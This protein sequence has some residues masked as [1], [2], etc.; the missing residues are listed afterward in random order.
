[1]HFQFHL[2]T[3]IYIGFVSFSQVVLLA[4]CCYSYNTLNNTLYS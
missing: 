3:K 1:M 4:F 2:N